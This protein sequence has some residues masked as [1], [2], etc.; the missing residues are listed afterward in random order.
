MRRV[1]K[2]MH[3]D[4]RVEGLQNRLYREAYYLMI[5]MAAVSIG[6]KFFRSGIQS[7]FFELAIIVLPSVYIVLRGLWIGIY[8]DE[9]EMQERKARKPLAGNR[10]MTGLGLGLLI[11]IGFGIRSALVYGAAGTYLYFLTIVFA[12]AMMIYIPVFLVLIMTPYLM[13]KRMQRSLLEND[14]S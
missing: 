3:L 9:L 13:A 12:A 11:S 7:I 14:D 10:L 8:A 5:L 6:I 4:E 2:N 1:F